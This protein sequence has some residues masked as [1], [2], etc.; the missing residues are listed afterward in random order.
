MQYRIRP[1]FQGLFLYPFWSLPG[2]T[3]SPLSRIPIGT[4]KAIRQACCHL[5]NLKGYQKRRLGL[6]RPHTYHNPLKD[7]GK[8]KRPPR[9]QT[10]S[11]SLRHTRTCKHL[12]QACCRTG[13]KREEEKYKHR[14]ITFPG[15]VGKRTLKNK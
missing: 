5:P 15:N 14:P 13:K 7:E 11:N 10:F 4:C 12:P 6:I 3:P 8:C 1:V 9:R 2:L